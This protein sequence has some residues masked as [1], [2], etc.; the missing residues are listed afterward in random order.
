MG[1]IIKQNHSVV[2]AADVDNL[3]YL[4][5]LVS[6]TQDVDGIGGYKLGSVL[7]TYYGLPSVISYVR[8]FTDL[9]II[10]DPQKGG[11]DTPNLGKNLAKAFKTAKA[12][13]VILFPLAGPQTQDKWIEAMQQEELEILIGGEMTHPQFKRSEGGYI[14]DDALDG[15][16]IRA[17]NS[18]VDNFV[19]PGNKIDRFTHYKNLLD[20]VVEKPVY[21]L[22][23][24][25]RQGGELTEIRKL[26]GERWHPIIGRAIYEARDMKEAA[27]EIVRKIGL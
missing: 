6:E 11:T 19:L 23:G 17:A 16:Y 1:E 8:N 24:F 5:T 21:Y 20:T 10:Y 27:K 18:G 26:A 22:T 13:A 3:D 12:N 4:K 7:T 2:I 15:I 25:V 9:P 14:A